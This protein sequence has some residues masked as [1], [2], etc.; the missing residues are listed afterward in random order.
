MLAPNVYGNL[1]KPYPNRKYCVL[2]LSKRGQIDTRVHNSGGYFPACA[3]NIHL[4][5]IVE[6]GF[7]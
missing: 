5:F 2:F 1:L 7:K 4:C 6:Y 3:V